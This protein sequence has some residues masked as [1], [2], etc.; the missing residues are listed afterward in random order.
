MERVY[1]PSTHPSKWQM[2]PSSQ[3]GIVKP[4]PKYDLTIVYP[5]MNEPKCLKDA[6]TVRS[7]A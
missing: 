3:K 1:V 7:Y 6:L 2:V 5:S 4:T